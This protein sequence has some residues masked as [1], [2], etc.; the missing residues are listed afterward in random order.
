MS[1]AEV[2]RILGMTPSRIRSLVRVG[3]RR[4]AGE[5]R[6]Y[7]F[8][9]PD[10]V[11]LRAAKE[12]FARH[13]PPSKVY[14]AL[15]ALA[16]EL[17]AGSAMS[18]LKIFADGGHVVARKGVHAWRPEDGQTVFNFDIDELAELVDADRTQ[19]EAGLPAGGHHDAQQEFE[20]ALATEDVD[21]SS[22]A[23]GYRRAIVLDAGH[24]DAHV[25]LGRLSHEQGSPHD[26]ARCYVRALHYRPDDPV[27]HFNLAL[28]VE[29]TLGPSFAVAHYIRTLELDPSFAD[30]HY[31]LA[32]LCD[33]LGRE[34]DAA[35]HLN[36]YRRLRPGMS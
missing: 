14:K 8:S 27:I 7:A 33:E 17:P 32:G 30:A 13:V 15:S 25:N 12:L 35:T 24:V 26:A 6:R 23:E 31:N 21:P 19:V 20:G 2:A 10:L 34:A 11:V 28:A 18:G 9:F 16:R 5:G 3:L 4:S 36:A 22:A 1:T 29:D